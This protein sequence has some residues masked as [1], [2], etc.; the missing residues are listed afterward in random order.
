MMCYP[1]RAMSP[2]TRNPGTALVAGAAGYLGSAIV[3]ALVAQDWR[4]VGLVRDTAKADR[5]AAL[6]ATAI[7]ADVRDAAAVAA[8]ARSTDVL[9][10][11]AAGGDP[12]VAE[13]LHEAENIRVLGARNLV[14]A[15][16]AHHVPRVVVG[17]GYWVYADQP[18]VIREDSPVDP[19]GEA[20]VNFHAELA[21][22]EETNSR[23]SPEVIVVRPGMVYGNGSWLRSVVDALRAGTYAVVADGTN[24]WSFVALDDAAAAFVRIAEAGTAGE[25][26]NVVDGRPAPWSEFADHLADRLGVRR[27]ASISV[28]EA[29]RRYGAEV[30]RHLAARRACTSQKLEQLGW[31]PR[32]ADYRDGLIPVLASMTR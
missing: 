25:T 4:V 12:Y 31:K 29:A 3:R 16:I 20:L 14:R 30:A 22:R 23:G 24:P 27:P 19:R 18:G 28:E 1:C 6:G 17:S 26:Y 11:V 32:Y 13:G 2:E 15:A 5:V 10:H 9:I 7:V 8:A 21:A